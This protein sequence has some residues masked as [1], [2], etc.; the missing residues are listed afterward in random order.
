MIKSKEMFT[1]YILTAAVILAAF[2]SLAGCCSGDSRIYSG[3]P[4]VIST[5]TQNEKCSLTVVANSAEIKDREAFARTVIKMYEANDFQTTKF[6]RD[7][8]SAPK[9]LYITVYLT[10]NDVA[11]EREAF[12][13]CYDTSAH[14]F[15]D[16]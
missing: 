16:F 1:K 6:S 5:R 13:F 9:I 2:L 7:M 14:T 10:R 11:E 3:V 8:G 12:R 4:D 15:S